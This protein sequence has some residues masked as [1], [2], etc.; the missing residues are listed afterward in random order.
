MAVFFGVFCAALSFWFFA[1]LGMDFRLH[2]SSRVNWRDIM[3]AGGAAS[4]LNSVGTKL[5]FNNDMATA[6]A[7]FLGDVTG[8]IVSMFILMLI[9]R[10]LRRVRSQG[11]V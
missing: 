4:V 9:F 2:K 3:L 6:S 10:M 7:R 11:G 5:F 8:M 1:L